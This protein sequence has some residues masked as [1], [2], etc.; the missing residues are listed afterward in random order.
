MR[1]RFLLA[2]VF[3]F[4]GGIVGAP[5]PQ[6]ACDV[7]AVRYAVEDFTDTAAI[8]GWTQRVAVSP[9]VLELRRM[10]RAFERADHAGCPAEAI[11]AITSGMNFIAVGYAFFLNE[12]D[13]EANAALALGGQ[14]IQ[15]GL[16]A[17]N[18]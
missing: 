3:L 15:R 7:E 6:A 18:Q 13:L 5:Q 16:E 9:L 17:L 10:H 11:E 12:E 8:A 2:F 14:N 4:T 1:Y